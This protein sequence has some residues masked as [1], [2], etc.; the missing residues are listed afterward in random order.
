MHRAARSRIGKFV[1]LLNYR[2]GR[3]RIGKGQQVSFAERAAQYL[4]A[5]RQPFSISPGR[6]GNGWHARQ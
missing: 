1:V 4:Q 5:N 3:Q 2:Y 6:N